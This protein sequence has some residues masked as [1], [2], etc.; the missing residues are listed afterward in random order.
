MRERGSAVRNK[1]YKLRQAIICEKGQAL[2]E[3]RILKEEEK[4]EMSLLVKMRVPQDF[5][6]IIEAAR[7]DMVDG[8]GLR[9]AVARSMELLIQRLD[10][11]Y[12]GHAKSDMR[13][14]LE[15]LKSEFMV[16]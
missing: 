16:F 12:N 7:G 4:K 11:D 14:A 1:M 9:K 2:E 3:L 8:E 6:P 5:S 15:S 13:H 10:E